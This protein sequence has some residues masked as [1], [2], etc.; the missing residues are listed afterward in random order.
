MYLAD[1]NVI[2]HIAPRRNPAA[3]G[4]ALSEWI[5]RQGSHIWISVVTVAELA[6]GAAD[7]R[8]RNASRRADQLDAWIEALTARHAARLLLI[9]AATARRA[10]TLLARAVAAGRDPGMEDAMIAATAERHGLVVLTRNVAD[11]TALG[12]ALANPFEALPGG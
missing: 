2:S 8:R 12:V 9:D 10:G 7:L 6:F 11:F 4:V 1:T 5:E 3:E